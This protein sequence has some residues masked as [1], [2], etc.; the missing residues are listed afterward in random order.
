[1]AKYVALYWNQ[2][3]VNMS[4]RLRAQPQIYSAVCSRSVPPMRSPTSRNSRHTGNMKVRF[5]TA[6]AMQPRIKS[7]AP[8]SLRAYFF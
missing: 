5:C 3:T 8:R 2:V 7:F 4:A 6:H 1:M